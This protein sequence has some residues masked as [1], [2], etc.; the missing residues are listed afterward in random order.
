MTREEAIIIAHSDPEVIIEF[1]LRMSETNER[2]QS[3]IEELER[4]IALLTR[5]SS[6]S[7]KPPSSDGPAVQW[8]KIC[9]GNQSPEGELYT[10]RLLTMIRTCSLQGKNFFQYLV[11][12]VNASRIGTPHPSLVLFSR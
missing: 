5:D 11:D 1:L 10:A 12:A 8:R 3:R 7:S 4:K 9:F 6:N 2:L